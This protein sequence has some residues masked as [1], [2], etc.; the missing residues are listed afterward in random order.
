M[1]KA[2][3]AV[4]RKP[5]TAPTQQ[6][7]EGEVMDDWFVPLEDVIEK[8]NGLL[9]GREGSGKTTDIARLANLPGNGKVLIINAEGGVKIGPLRKRGVDTSKVVLWPDPKKG[10]ALNHKSLDALFRRIQADLMRDP[11]SW[12]GIGIDSVTEIYQAVLDDVQQR[13]VGILRNKGAEPDEFFVDISDYGTMSKM[14][15]DLFRKFRDL[16]CHVFFTALERRDIDKDTGK[17]QYGPDVTPALQKDV[18][19]YVDV[20]LMCKSEDEDGPYRAL[21]RGNSRYRAKDRFDV[22][23]RVMAEPTCDRIVQYVLGEMTVDT[24]PFQDDL[25]DSAKTAQ[26]RVPAKPDDDDED[27]E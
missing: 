15:R 5:K 8:V 20:V 17:P 25:P 19:G 13:R 16:P 27:D 22:L 23:P 10:E 21:T 6:V 7:L 24:D 4:A 2:T 12:I 14:V 1:P 18:L 9:Y 26:D 11:H 3:T